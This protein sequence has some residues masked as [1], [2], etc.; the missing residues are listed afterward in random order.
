MEHGYNVTGI[1]TDLLMV[2]IGSLLAIIGGA[3]WREVHEL[4]K[5]AVRR[6]KH[7]TLLSTMMRQVCTKLGIPYD[8]E[9]ADG[10]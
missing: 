10:D 4:R 3:M 7:I 5:D 1:P 9:D 2:C 6:G 8:V